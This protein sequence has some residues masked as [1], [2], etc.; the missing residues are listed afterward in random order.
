MHIHPNPPLRF[1][2]HLALMWLFVV[3]VGLAHSLSP[4]VCSNRQQRTIRHAIEISKERILGQGSYGVVFAA[5]D[6]DQQLVAKCCREDALSRRYLEIERR[7]NERVLEACPEES[8]YVGHI[9]E[10]LFRKKYLIFERVPGG[11]DVG[12]YLSDGACGIE[13][14]AAA[15]GIESYCAGLAE[16]SIEGDTCRGDPDEARSGAGN[17]VVAANVV[18]RISRSLSRLHAIGICHR[19]VKPANLL[20]DP[21]S[22]RIRLID[23]GSALDLK[24]GAGRDDKRSPVSP[25][26][27]A[28]EQFVRKEHWQSFDSYA[29]G[30]TALRILLSP[31]L[32]SENDVDIFNGE[33]RAAHRR[34]DAWLG[35][36]L[37]TTAVST[38][39][40]TPL[41]AM[42]G[43][44]S[45]GWDRAT[46][47]LW[48][49]IDRLTDEEPSS[50]LDCTAGSA[51]A[52]D[53]CRAFER[54]VLSAEDTPS[55]L[56]PAVTSWEDMKLSSQRQ[57]GVVRVTLA[58]PLGVGIQDDD[59]GVFVA[60]VFPGGSA[61]ALGVPKVNDRILYFEWLGGSRTIQRVEDAESAMRKIAPGALFEVGVI[62]ADAHEGGGEV[63]TAAALRLE[64]GAYRR[65]GEGRAAVED[66]VVACSQEFT[67][68]LNAR[69]WPSRKIVSERMTVRT[70]KPEA[71]WLFAAVA[72]GHG[73]QDAS[74]HC[75]L[76]LPELMKSEL[77]NR[78]PSRLD[79]ALLSAW[80][81]CAAE[82]S[83][84]DG[85]GG[86]VCA[87]VCVSPDA[88]ATLHCG[89]AR[90]V[91]FDATGRLLFETR[92]HSLRDPAERNALQKRG[93]QF[94]GGRVV[95]D[96]WRVAVPRAI[97]GNTWLSAGI[98]P[99][100]D[101]MLLNRSDDLACVLVA[102]DGVWDVFSSR[103]A[104]LYVSA[105]RRFR[106]KDD[107]S[108][109]AAHLCER[110]VNLGSTDDV[111]AA[112]L[113][114][115][116][117]NKAPSKAYS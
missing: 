54:L 105:R 46:S 101:L 106:P 18:E 45:P 22:K 30:L 99:V 1:F 64:I 112:I 38:K 75:A 61:E 74:A 47:A 113:F 110:A 65:R 63:L 92:D 51:A 84:Y 77:V 8:L 33:F 107:A 96:Q 108:E 79:A 21:T 5:Q 95:A 27:C 6:G 83:A 111:S 29:I 43:T 44:A 115:A 91:G 73:G 59:D 68:R 50:R 72:D 58:A 57:D 55:F 9:E 88:V 87:A 60:E 28:P 14:L 19:D 37:S 62:E 69:D 25:R 102:S 24:T 85:H 13:A 93:G 3:V 49:L 78:D 100:P 56:G 90:L 10:G 23:F 7:V 81:R 32:R 31:A 11:R 48:R 103:E 40:L 80:T 17:V 114:L 94:D 16:C 71:S 116:A 36:K 76:R 66:A 39:L 35:A 67:D 82:Y 15:L 109:I 117:Q 34:L 2:Q 20:V 97:G 26:Y 104:A 4:R 41:S 42:R 53:L 70:L 86:A 89:D 12:S 98:A 52:A